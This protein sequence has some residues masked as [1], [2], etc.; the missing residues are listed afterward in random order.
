MK[1][2][3]RYKTSHLSE[4]QFEKDSQGRVLKNLLGIYRKRQMDKLEAQE[5][6][7][8]LEE[9]TSFYGVNHRFRAKDI[10]DI[11][12]NWLGE[13]YEWA[14]QYRSVNISKGGFYFAMAREVPKLMDEFENGV[15]AQHTPC[16]YST[17]QEIA[18]AL[19]VVHVELVLIHPFREGNGRLARLIS[20]LMALQA[21]LP[22][23]D[24]G[25]IQGRKK[26]EYI[27]AVQK[28]LDRDY[29]PMTRIFLS[30]IKRTIKSVS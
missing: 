20:I 11:H 9:I 8:T 26:K 1:K 22:V 29:E 2:D 14:G 6:L 19:A 21:G 13:I 24:F 15:L 28:G 30:V 25:G 5:Q 3:K 4:N 27:I 7:R 12:K 16:H 17:H 23:L 10:C 18:E